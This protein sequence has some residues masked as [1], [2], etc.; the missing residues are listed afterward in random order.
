MILLIWKER[1]H[2]LINQLGTLRT[3]SREK[4]QRKCSFL[5]IWGEIAK[6]FQLVCLGISLVSPCLQ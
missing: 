5:N 2:R 6:M 1:W 4:V 3:Y